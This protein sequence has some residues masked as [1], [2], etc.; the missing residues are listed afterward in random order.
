MEDCWVER[1]ANKK[2]A[3]V[4]LHN[5]RA[6]TL[7]NVATWIHISLKLP[8][9]YA[10]HAAYPPSKGGIAVPNRTHACLLRMSQRSSL[11][12]L[13]MGTCWAILP[14]R[15]LLKWSSVLHFICHT[16]HAANKD[17]LFVPQHNQAH[18]RISIMNLS[19]NPITTI[20]HFI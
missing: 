4:S 12:I 1:I 15:I 17:T 8:Q 16:M 10:V 2:H 9:V 11:Q 5:W 20:A 6:W 13:S 18:M 14:M 7:L 3:S 19:L